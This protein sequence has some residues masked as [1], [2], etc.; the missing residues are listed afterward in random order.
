L[1]VIIADSDSDLEYKKRIFAMERGPSVAH[2]ILKHGL[3]GKPDK[4]TE[5]LKKYVDAGVDQFFLAF[6]DPFDHKALDL[7]MKASATI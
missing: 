6:Q 5:K 1:D 2:Q 4:I 7:F 3:V